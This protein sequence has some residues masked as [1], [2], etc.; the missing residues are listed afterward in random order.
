MGQIKY[1]S[2]FS[3]QRRVYEASML[4]LQVA[5]GAHTTSPPLRHW[6][7]EACRSQLWGSQY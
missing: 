6:G 3:L 5:G 1:K 2:V 7:D 4:L